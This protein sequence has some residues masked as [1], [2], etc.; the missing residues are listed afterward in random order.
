MAV[1]GDIAYDL[2]VLA[3]TTGL[4]AKG[5]A[6]VWVGTSGLGLAGALNKAA[7]HNGLDVQGAANALA[8][9]TGIGEGEVLS[10][11]VTIKQGGTFGATGA[12]PSLWLDAR[13]VTGFGSARPADGAT[14]Q[15]W[16]DLSGNS[17]SAT[18][19]TAGFRP[20]YRVSATGL[21]KPALVFDGVDDYMQTTQWVGSQPQTRYLV[22]Y[23]TDNTVNDKHLCSTM[24]ATKREDIYIQLSQSSP[25]IFSGSAASGSSSVMGSPVVLTVVFNGASSSIR[26]N[27]AN[28]ASVSP[29]AGQTNGFTIAAYGGGAVSNW[30]PVT[31]GAVLSFESAHSA[32][33]RTNVERA[34][35]TMYGIAVA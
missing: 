6:N 25:R 3:G 17:R 4:D 12:G 18:Q 9:T 11:L 7:G 15:T 34:L 29:G 5:A 20:V 16:T 13:S 24:D 28:E 35:G 1:S 22:F 33:Q 14:V 30:A 19:G 2:N 31:L 10:P 27:G 21:N 26:V 8:G 23:I 32:A